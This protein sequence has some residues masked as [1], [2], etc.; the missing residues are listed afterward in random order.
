MSDVL[1]ENELEDHLKKCPEWDI[2]EST[3]YRSIEFEDFG[4]AIDFVNTVADLAEEAQHHPE[5]NIVY[6]VV[7]LTLTTTDEGGVTTADIE[8]AQRLD[9]LI[10]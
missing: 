9:N 3:I 1:D 5:I 7:T 6:S 2:H 4:E 10:D 8:M